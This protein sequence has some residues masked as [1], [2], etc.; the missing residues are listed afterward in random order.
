MDFLL[1]GQRNFLENGVLFTI[2]QMGLEESLGIIYSYCR[3]WRYRLNDVE[4]LKIQPLFQEFL[5]FFAKKQFKKGVKEPLLT[6]G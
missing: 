6:R 4:I 5:G 3:A 2:G 1:K